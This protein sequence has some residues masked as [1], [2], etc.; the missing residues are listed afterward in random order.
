MSTLTTNL[1]LKLISD[2]DYVTTDPFNENF[3]ILDNLGVDYITEQGTSG[4]WTYRKFKSGIYEMWG[5]QAFAATS[6]SG[7]ISATIWYPITFST[8]PFV[9][10][11]CGVYGRNDAYMAYVDGQKNGIDAW[12]YKG[13]EESLSYWVYAHVI[14]KV[15]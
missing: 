5:K 12:L 8:A 15:S 10:C 6:N 1:K 14:G 9:T 4:I 7:L 13:S 2:D 3:K 11:S